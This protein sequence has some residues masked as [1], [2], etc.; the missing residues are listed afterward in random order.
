MYHRDHERLFRKFGKLLIFYS[1]IGVRIEG[2]ICD[3]DGGQDEVVVPWDSLKPNLLDPLTELQGLY[4]R[5]ELHFKD[6]DA[7]DH[8]PEPT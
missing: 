7:A 5:G 2:G 3:G 4:D 1:S 6:E 8:K